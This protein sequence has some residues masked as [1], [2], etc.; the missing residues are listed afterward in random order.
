MICPYNRSAEIQ[1]LQTY[2][3]EEDGENFCQQVTRTTFTRLSCPKEAAPSGRTGAAA[4]RRW[5]RRTSENNRI[6]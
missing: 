6:R 2:Q 4:M 3:T 1:V 5:T